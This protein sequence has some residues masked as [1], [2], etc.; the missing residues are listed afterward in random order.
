MPD[1]TDSGWTA[2][3]APAAPSP[4]AMPRQLSTPTTEPDPAPETE[5]AADGGD[6]DQPEASL[7]DLHRAR[8]IRVENKNLRDRA[9]AAEQ[10][11]DSLL[12]VVDTLRRG[13]VERLAAQ[14]LRDPRDLLDRTSVAHFLTED[15]HVDPNL[16]TA[17]AQ[18]LIAD[19]PHVAAPP[20]VTAPPTNRP[21]EQLTPGASPTPRTE[22]TSWHSA[23]GRLIG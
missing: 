20:P 4:A 11:R 18:E 2:D 6:D 7:H 14:H 16:V 17:A 12:N 22:P 23:L 10:E 1:T 5:P 13:E 3:D 9:K 8:A 21:I 15:G 19:R